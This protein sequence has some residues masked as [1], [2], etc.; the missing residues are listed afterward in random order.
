M[1]QVLN[2][3]VGIAVTVGAVMLIIG[4]LVALG[5]VYAGP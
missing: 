2:A 3:A 1:R 4:A 5:V